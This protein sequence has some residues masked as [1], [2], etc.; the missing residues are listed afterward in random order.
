MAAVVRYGVVRTGTGRKVG[1][2][3]S[4]AVAPNA[5]TEGLIAVAEGAGAETVVR[6]VAIGALMVT[7]Q[8]GGGEAGR[9]SR[10]AV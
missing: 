6:L 7:S 2:L 5:E 4:G 9:G 8:R 1:R 10:S 3:L